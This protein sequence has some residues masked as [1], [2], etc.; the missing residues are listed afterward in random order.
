[1]E[2]GETLEVEASKSGSSFLQQSELQSDA[3]QSVVEAEVGNNHQKLYGGAQYHRS[4]R[5]FTVAVRH[6]AAQVV[7]EDEIANAAG[8]C[9]LH[10]LDMT[11]SADWW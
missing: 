11:L 2:W 6:M 8:A 5:E 3:W 10:V 7:T 1:M 4:M 9:A